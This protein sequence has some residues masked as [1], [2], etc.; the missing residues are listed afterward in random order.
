MLYLYNL[1]RKIVEAWKSQK[2]EMNHYRLHLIKQR[3]VLKAK[4][5][6]RKPLLAMKNIELFR[7]WQLFVDNC[8]AK[9]RLKANYQT[10]TYATYLRLMRKSLY[11]L[12]L[13]SA[14]NF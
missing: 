11:A 9:T 2:N 6:L 3:A 4:P 14:Q 8:Q 7:A 5:E 1:R 10:S 13:N 12:R